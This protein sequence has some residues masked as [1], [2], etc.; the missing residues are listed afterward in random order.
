MPYERCRAAGTKV[1]SKSL[2]KAI[3]ATN[4]SKDCEPIVGSVVSYALG[5]DVVSSANIQIVTCRRLRGR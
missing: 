4:S 3:V 5:A 2:V 1:L